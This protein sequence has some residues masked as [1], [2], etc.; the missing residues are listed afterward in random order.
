[1]TSS[2]WLEL[3]GETR[4]SVRTSSSSSSFVASSSSSRE[5]HAHRGIGVPLLESAPERGGVRRPRGAIALERIV[6]DLLEIVVAHVEDGERRRRGARDPLPRLG[7]APAAEG[8]RPV[9]TS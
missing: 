6:E 8:A 2:S 7:V 5:Q 3:N 1:M 9:S 4:I